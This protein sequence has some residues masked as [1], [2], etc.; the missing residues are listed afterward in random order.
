MIFQEKEISKIFLGDQERQVLL[1][2]CMRKL[3][4]QYI[5]NEVQERK[6]YGL[7]G[8]HV[9][10]GVLYIG[11]IAPLYQNSRSMGEDKKHMDSMLGEHAQASETPLEKRGWVADPIETITIINDF[12]SNDLELVGAYHMHRVAWDNDPTREGP[13]ALDTELAKESQL[14]VFIISLVKP[15][16]PV[17]RAFYEG[18]PDQ[19]IQIVSQ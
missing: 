17:I 11:Q 15:E 12:D 19:E 4:Q 14:F 9:K 10:E 5:E 13:S 1:A 18:F 16:L 3:N 7:I 8:G 2:H 6:A